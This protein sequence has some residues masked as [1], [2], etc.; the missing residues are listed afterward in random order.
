MKPEHGILFK[1]YLSAHMTG[2]QDIVNQVLELVEAQYL[3]R[4]SQDQ[5]RI[6]MEKIE[7]EKIE[8]HIFELEDESGRLKGTATEQ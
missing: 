4:V 2:R 3:P 1:N 6:K 7:L 5:N 8:S